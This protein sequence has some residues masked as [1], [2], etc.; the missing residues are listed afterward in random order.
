MITIVLFLGGASR[1]LHVG[2]RSRWRN[3]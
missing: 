2:E 1:P 3:V